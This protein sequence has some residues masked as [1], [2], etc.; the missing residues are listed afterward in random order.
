MIKVRDEQIKEADIFD[1]FK[2]VMMHLENR[3]AKEY[4]ATQQCQG[5]RLMFWDFMAKGWKG[6]NF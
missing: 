5:M 6:S 4:K 1:V 3:D 2:G